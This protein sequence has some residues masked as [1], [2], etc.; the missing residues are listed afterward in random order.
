[1]CGQNG[2][3]CTNCNATGTLADGCSATG[4]CT[5]G[6]GAACGSGQACIGGMCR[7]T[8]TTCPTGCCQGDTCVP[9]SSQS[10]LSCGTSG[11]MCGACPNLNPS[12]VTGACHCGASSTCV[13][14]QICFGACV[15]NSISCPSG[16]CAGNVCVLYGS[17]TGGQCGAGGAA[18]GGCPAANPQ[19][20]P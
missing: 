16:C 2:A 6:G 8:A 3:L 14:G 7:C 19:C 12:C 5:C 11:A 15:C 20:D 13:A 9:Y 1:Q 17:Q 4:A 18:C 10:D